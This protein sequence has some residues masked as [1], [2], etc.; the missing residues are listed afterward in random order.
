M[1]EKTYYIYKVKYASCLMTNYNNQTI[2]VWS[3]QKLEN[4]SFIVVEHEGYGV[5][6]GQVIEEIEDL[7]LYLSK[8]YK[9]LKNID[10]S[11]WV[12][13]IKRK[14]RVAELEAKMENRFE[15]IDR[16][17]RYEYYAELDD[18]FRELYLEY[19]RLGGNNQ[20]E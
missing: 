3:T 1:K 20:D 11:E 12:D 5:F 19:E 2:E 15:D 6:I 14:E 18:R 13:E 9:F 10:L 8:E 17:K 7:R 4:D 16:K